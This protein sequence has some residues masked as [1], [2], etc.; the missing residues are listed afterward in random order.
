[1]TSDLRGRVESLV[2]RCCAVRSDN[3]VFFLVGNPAGSH[4]KYSA[5]K[6]ERLLGWSPQ[7]SVASYF[8][9]KI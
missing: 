2:Y 9:A 3:E 5:E 1:M 6:S 8:T 7:D 4:G